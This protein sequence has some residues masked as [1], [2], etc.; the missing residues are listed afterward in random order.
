MWLESLCREQRP[1][2]DLK[3]AKDAEGI[4]RSDWQA[5]LAMLAD[6]SLS[7]E[8]RAECFHS[9]MAQIVVDQASQLREEHNI[10]HIGLTGGVFQ[11]RVL[12][13]TCIERLGASG[14]EVSLASALPCNDGG[15]CFG[16][17]IELA[18]REQGKNAD[19]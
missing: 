3:L 18:A 12:A 5:L 19:G 13:D 7:A 17:A 9:S 4:W 16:Q 2:V 6:E 11:N 15:L 14:F 10:E 8:H 1:P